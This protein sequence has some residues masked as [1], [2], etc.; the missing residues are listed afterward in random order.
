MAT[1]RYYD[2]ASGTWKTEQSTPTSPGGGTGTVTIGQVYGLTAALADLVTKHNDQAT[3][4]TSLQNQVAANPA[5]LLVAV[6]P[7]DTQVQRPVND[8]AR[9]VVWIKKTAPAAGGFPNAEAQDVWWPR[10]F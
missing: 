6:C 2:P 10:D 7:N 3:L 1:T 5:A 4:I 8:P 9:V